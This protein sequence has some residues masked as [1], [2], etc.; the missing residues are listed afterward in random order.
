MAICI[1]MVGKNLLLMWVTG[2]PIFVDAV[3]R[4]AKHDRAALNVRAKVYQ[5]TRR[6][7]SMKRCFFHIRP[8]GLGLALDSQDFFQYLSISVD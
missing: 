6:W 5:S 7:I 3:L 4:A 8:Q 1:Y 2:R